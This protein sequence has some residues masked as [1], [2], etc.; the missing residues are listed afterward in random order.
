MDKNKKIKKARRVNFV[1]WMLIIIALAAVASF[2]YFAFF[3]ELDLF[4]RSHDEISVQYTIRVE[5]VNT[6]YLML[7]AQEKEGPL[8]AHFIS[9]GDKVYDSN[10]GKLIGRVSSLR[11]EQSTAPTGK[12]DDNN[13]NLVYAPY[14]K[15]VDLI[16]TVS[17]SG[18][19]SSGVISI[20]GYE[21]RI[22]NEI[23]FRTEKYDAVGMCTYVGGKEKS[24]DGN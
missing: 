11:Y 1:D 5:K 9:V 17:G 3:S 18:Y 24:T 20:D 19:E 12:K 8:E 7:N 21:I 4:G 2:V 6:E 14:P 13:G 16:I 15:H 10:G 22:G 23:S